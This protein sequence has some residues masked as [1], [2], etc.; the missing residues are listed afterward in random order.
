MMIAAGLGS[1]FLEQHQRA[2]M[3]HKLE[4]QEADST[5]GKV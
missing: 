4:K 3:N 1:K 2:H 5:G